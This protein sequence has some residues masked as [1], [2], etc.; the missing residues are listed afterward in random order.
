MILK[1]NA[2]EK[3]IGIREMHDGLDFQYKNNSHANRLIQFVQTNFVSRHKM[4]K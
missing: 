4:S 3:T 1:H 2:H